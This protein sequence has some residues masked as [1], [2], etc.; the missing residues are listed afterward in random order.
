MGFVV[1]GKNYKEGFNEKILL[2]LN[3]SML[4]KC[5]NHVIYNSDN[6]KMWWMRET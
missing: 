5:L 3:W 6:I 1:F 2:I 4:V